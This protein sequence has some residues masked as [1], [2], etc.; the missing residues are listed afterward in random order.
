[1]AKQYSRL[2]VVTTRYGVSAPTIWRWEKAGIFP[3]RKRLGPNTVAWDNDE[4]DAHDRLL[5]VGIATTKPARG[6]A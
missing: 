2:P 1:M 4:L 6:V 3:K 5:P